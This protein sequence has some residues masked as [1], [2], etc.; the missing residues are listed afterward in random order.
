VDNTRHRQC[1]GMQRHSSR[2]LQYRH[3]LTAV[4]V[5]SII[6]PPKCA[7]S[8]EFSVSRFELLSQL[9]EGAF[10]VVYKAKDRETEEIVALKQLKPEIAF[11][12]GVIEHFRRELVF[13]RKITHRNV[14]RVF[15]LYRED[16]AVFISMEYVEGERLRDCLNREAPLPVAKCLAIANQ[17]LDGLAQAHK[18]DVVHRDLKPENIMISEAGVVKIMDFGLARSLDPDVT[19]STNALKGTPAYMSPE[20]AQAQ[21]VDARSDI[22]S[23][24]LILYEMFCGRRAIAGGSAIS[25]AMKQVN[26]T[27]VPASEVAPQLPTFIANAIM[28][29]LNKDPSERFDSVASLQTALNSEISV[30]QGSSVARWRKPLIAVS[31]ALLAIAVLAFG[32]NNGRSLTV[33][34]QPAAVFPSSQGV[35]SV[36]PVS[37]RQ[38]PTPEALPSIA[39]LDFAN[40]QNEAQYAGFATT[41]PEALA[42]GFVGSKRFRVVERMQLEKLMKELQLDQSGAVDPASAQ[43]LGKLVGAQYFII[44]SYQVFQGDILINARLLRVETGEIL[45]TDKVTGRSSSALTLPDRLASSFLA[46]MNP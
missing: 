3:L 15:D 1:F 34:P 10:G 38:V 7:F 20:Q 33:P 35:I 18:C 12:R 9:G 32:M 19:V 30:S 42:A 11:Q 28:K 46:R 16:P 39:I 21:P 43:R 27:P 23:V 5:G 14:C 37:A 25:I 8:S 41:I 29:C 17:M 40:L 44:G 45:G 4:A 6:E 26:E 31:A 2:G 13:T 24:G 36:P 22:Y